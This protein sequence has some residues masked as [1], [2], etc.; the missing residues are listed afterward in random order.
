MHSKRLVFGQRTHTSLHSV[1]PQRFNQ[2]HNPMVIANFRLL[3]RTLLLT[4]TARWA[5]VQN[6]NNA[7]GVNLHPAFQNRTG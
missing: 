2:I 7:W 3:Q 4:T 6:I 5:S 1:S